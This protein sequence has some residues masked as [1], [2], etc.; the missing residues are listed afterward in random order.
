MR[1]APIPALTPLRP[2]GIGKLGDT[3]RLCVGD[4][5]HLPVALRL[6]LRGKN[7][8][9][10]PGSG[11][12]PQQILTHLGGRIGQI[13]NLAVLVIGCREPHHAAAKQYNGRDHLPVS[14]ETSHELREE[15][16]PRLFRRHAF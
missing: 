8:R 3:L 6:K 12:A 16:R 10:V 9:A 5:T 13:G 2:R 1:V 14:H 7:P 4:G 15:P 11:C